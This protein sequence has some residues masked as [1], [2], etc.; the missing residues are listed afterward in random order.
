MPETLSENHASIIAQC[1][2]DLHESL[3]TLME[4]SGIP[5]AAAEDIVQDVFVKLMQVDT[6]QADQVNNLARVIAFQKRSDWFRRRARQRRH[7]ENWVLEE[8]YT[9]ST[10]IVAELCQAEKRAVARL[11]RVD[12]RVY[13]LSR[14]DGLSTKEIAERISLT[15]RAVES[16]LYRARN[17]IRRSLSELQA[18]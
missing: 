12:A 18:S 6:L 4:R 2:S 10:L 9:D 3:L 5:T 13:T 11:N 1:Y 8:A 14:Y 7:A 17:I 16:R 15:G